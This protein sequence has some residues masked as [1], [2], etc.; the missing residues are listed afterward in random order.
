MTTKQKTAGVLVGSF[1]GLI[2]ILLKLWGKID[3]AW[4]WVLLPFWLPKLIMGVVVVVVIV[5]VLRFIL[6][7]RRERRTRWGMFRGWWYKKISERRNRND[8]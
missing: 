1:A 4:M 7:W 2:L 6:K 8:K 3:L 5:V